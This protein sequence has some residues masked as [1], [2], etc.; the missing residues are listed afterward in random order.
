MIILDTILRMQVYIISVS[1]LLV[2]LIKVLSEKD[3]GGFQKRIFTIL[4]Y[5]TLCGLIDEAMGWTFDGKPGV[6]ARIIVTISN[7]IEM[8]LV[9]IPGILWMIYANYFIYN[10]INVI[11]KLVRLSGVVLIYF[12]ILS[13]SAPFN[14]L[15]FYIDSANRYHRGNWFWQSQCIYCMF[16]IYLVVILYF[17]KKRIHYNDFIPLLLF[18]VPPLVG[19]SIQMIYYGTS[20]AWSGVSVSILIVYIY[21]QSQKSSQ[22]YLTGLYNRRELDTYLGN[23]IKGNVSNKIVSIL[24]IDIDKFKTINDTWGHEMGDRALKLCAAI[25]RKCFHNE[26]FIARYAGDEF[27]VVLQLR[28]KKDIHKVIK[29]LKDTVEVMN[30]KVNVPYKLSFSIGYAILPDD[31]QD[32][33]QVIKIADERMYIEKDRA[34]L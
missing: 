14:K 24:M 5:F 17:N 27:V 29:R 19:M 13:V 12:V 31:G 7:M 25:L 30:C 23:T 4:I 28:N 22:D 16:F 10:S 20:L 1:M 26:D 2:M 6:S 18:P 32:L 3:N 21:I 34:K 33:A 9:L 8:V 15:L 11:K